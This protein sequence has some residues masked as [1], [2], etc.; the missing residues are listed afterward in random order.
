MAMLIE[1]SKVIDKNIN[2]KKY[3]NLT[4]NINFDENIARIVNAVPF[5]LYSRVTMNDEIVVLN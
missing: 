2:N 1:I 3:E 5:T 4:K